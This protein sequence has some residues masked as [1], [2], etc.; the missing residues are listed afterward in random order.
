MSLAIVGPRSK[1]ARIV[2]PYPCH[3]GAAE[4]EK[5]TTPRGNRLRGVW[6]EPINTS[7]HDWRKLQ[8]P[9]LSRLALR[10]QCAPGTPTLSQKA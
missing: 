4:E 1:T 8:V 9:G 6:G 10:T 7:P 2:A 3:L 5:Y